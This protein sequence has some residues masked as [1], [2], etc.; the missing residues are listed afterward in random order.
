[1]LIK[2]TKRFNIWP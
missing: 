2:K 1:V